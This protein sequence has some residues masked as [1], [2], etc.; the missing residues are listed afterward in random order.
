MFFMPCRFHEIAWQHGKNVLAGTRRE[1]GHAQ[2]TI[3]KHKGGADHVDKL[4]NGLGG[5]SNS[6]DVY[7]SH[8]K[9]TTQ[10]DMIELPRS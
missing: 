2:V 7:M 8:G 9:G 3:E 10:P 5:E 1:Y 4:F 6:L